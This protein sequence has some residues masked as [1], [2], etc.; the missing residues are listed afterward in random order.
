MIEDFHRLLFDIHPLMVPGAG[1]LAL[2]LVAWISDV[3]AKRRLVRLARRIA[4]SECFN[5]G[6]K[7]LES[8]HIFAPPLK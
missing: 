3:F 6:A 2:L 5:F 4:G 8:K 7:A 1:L